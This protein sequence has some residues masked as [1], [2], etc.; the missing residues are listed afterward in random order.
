VRRALSGLTLR[1]R[2]FLAAG[3]TATACAILLGQSTL[4]RLGVLALLLPLVSVVVVGRRRHQVTLTRTLSPALT[5]A[6]DT[7]RVDLELHNRPGDRTG[8]LLVEDKLPW[9]LGTPQRFLLHELGRSW[10]R[11]VSYRVRPE[12]RGQFSIGP[13]TVTDNDPFGLVEVTSVA[14]GTTTLTVTPR[15]VAL[16]AIPIPGT[17]GGSGDHRPRSAAVGSA[18]DVTVREYRRGDELRRVHWRSSARRGELMVRK[19]EQPWEAQA[20]VLLDN[21]AARHHGRGLTSSFEL[22]VT[23]AASVAVHLEQRGYAVRF[24]TADTFH[25][26]TEGTAIRILEQLA[27]VDLVPTTVLDTSWTP[28]AG[29]CGLIV[30]VLGAVTDADLGVLRRLRHHHDSALALV[31]DL[32]QWSGV[33]TET[34]RTVTA[35]LAAIGWTATELSPGGRLDTAWAGL[36]R[37]APSGEVAR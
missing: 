3:L 36:A 22:A 26:G 6:G 7:C 10:R 12:V 31:L 30:G 28:D 23:A 20:T 35:P 8:A 37:V 4:V 27:V 15:T 34:A 19:E 17:R 21:R 1:G 32:G 18:E 13:L 24:A 16:P 11:T 5:T 14:S 29:N 9:A 33:A 25:A 2:A